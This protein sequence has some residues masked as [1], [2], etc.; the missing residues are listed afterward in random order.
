[1][2]ADRVIVAGI[3]IIAL[4]AILLVIAGACSFCALCVNFPATHGN[5]YPVEHREDKTAHAG[6]E[7]ISIDATTFGGDIEIIESVTGNVEVVYDVYASRDRLDEITTETTYTE[8]NG[9]LVIKTKA[10]FL[11]DRMPVLGTRGANLRIS[12]PTDA[13]YEIKL[14]TAGGDV[15]VPE[16]NCSK[17]LVNTAGGNVDLKG[18]NSDEITAHT[19]GG[20]IRAKYTADEAVF[21]TAGGNI[22]LTSGQKSGTIEANT[23]GGNI[24]LYLDRDTL[25]SIDARTLGGFV[26]RGTIPVVTTESHASSLVGYTEGGRGDLS[27]VLHTMGGNIEVSY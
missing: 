8:E 7:K 27:I 10:K 25:F 15:N 16:L 14:S 3:A 17:I 1:M 9:T 24:K 21:D 22:Y 12:M 26:S 4:L 20:D 13:A 6:A 18:I 19:A 2:K 11:N 23:A 5:T